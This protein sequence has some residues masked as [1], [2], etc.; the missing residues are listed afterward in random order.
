ILDEVHERG[1]DSDLLNLLIKKL[2][3]TQKSSTRL[4]IM[5]ATLQAN[6]FGQYFTPQSE[7]VRDTIFVGARRYPVEVYFLDE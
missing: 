4:V 6:L 2:T 3:Q 7:Q 5:S 1:M